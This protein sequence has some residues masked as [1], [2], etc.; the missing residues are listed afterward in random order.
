MNTWAEANLFLSQQL[1]DYEETIKAK[2]QY[3]RIL[4]NKIFVQEQRIDEVDPDGFVAQA[5]LPG[6]GRPHLLILGDQ[7]LGPA[8]SVEPD[9]R[10]HSSVLHPGLGR[11]AHDPAPPAARHNVDS[12]PPSTSRGMPVT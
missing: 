4:K 7:H 10:R 3:I 11:P 5:T 12:S 8:V 2:D 1:R 6:A 9:R